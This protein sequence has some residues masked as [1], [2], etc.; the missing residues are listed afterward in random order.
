MWGN[1]GNLADVVGSAMDKV[2]AVGKDLEARINAFG[3]GDTAAG[4][5][6]DRWYAHRYALALRLARTAAGDFAEYRRKSGRLDFQDLLLLTA[7]LLR[8]NPGARADLGRRYRRLLVDEFQDTSL[9][10]Y[11]LIR[12]LAKPQDRVFVVGD[13]DQAIYSWRGAEVANIRDK[14]D[15][16]F[17]GAGTVLLTKNYRS[18]STIVKAARAVI[19]KLAAHLG[20]SA[21][22]ESTKSGSVG[23]DGHG[24]SI[25]GRGGSSRQPLACHSFATDLGLP[26]VASQPPQGVIR[27]GRTLV[28]SQ[29]P[30]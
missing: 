16:D 20:R 7:R 14:F 26:S 10:Q 2:A 22:G 12:V 29:L 23:I 11:E 18:T 17:K 30:R 21:H 6:L 5:L 15:V 24:G 27:R 25:D 4:R 9:S 19:A 8:A 28:A 3:V 13:V 1:L